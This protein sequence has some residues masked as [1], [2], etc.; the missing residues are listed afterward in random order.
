MFGYYFDGDIFDLKKFAKRRMLSMLFAPTSLYKFEQIVFQKLFPKILKFVNEFKNVLQYKD[1]E[2]VKWTKKDSHKKLSYLCFQ[3]EAK[4]MIENIARDFYKLH[5]GKVP[6]FT[7]HDCILT[8]TSHAEEIKEF[9]Q[10][11]FKTLLGIAPN[12][13]LEH[14]IF[15]NSYRNAS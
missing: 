3:F 12:L 5:K 9:M 15:E 2:E 13:T 10:N 7:L 1:C 8:T 14:S 4:T 11:K 6:V